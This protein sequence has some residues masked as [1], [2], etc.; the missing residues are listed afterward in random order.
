[1]RLEELV[2]ALNRDEASG[3]LFRIGDGF[4]QTVAMSAN[5]AEELLDYYRRTTEL[6]KRAGQVEDL[7]DWKQNVKDVKKTTD[8]QTFHFNNICPYFVVAE[9]LR[10]H[11]DPRRT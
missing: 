11:S 4:G 5:S 6:W 3:S 9:V 8:H 7:C 2:R 1:M 10:G